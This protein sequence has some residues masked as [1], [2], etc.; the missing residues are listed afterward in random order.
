[1]GTTPLQRS[2]IAAVALAL[3]A[4]TVALVLAG[5]LSVSY[6]PS[7]AQAWDDPSLGGGGG[8]WTRT[9]TWV[10]AAWL[11]ATAAAAVLATLL[12][13]RGARR[14]GGIAL[15][16]C[17]VAGVGAAVALATRSLVQWDQLALWAVEV[18]GSHYDGYWRAA[19]DDG[20]RFVLVDG[21]EVATGD[22][23]AALAVHLLA[24]LV[25]VVGLAGAV[26]ALRAPGAGIRRPVA[27]D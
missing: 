15:A 27:A 10:T 1:M 2:T 14:R 25:G 8:G 12:A 23:A 20:V 26:L 17:V 3:T 6:R 5:V 21:V 9:H 13:V 7:A 11:V 16:G 18:G 19:F 24:H 22:Y 4:A